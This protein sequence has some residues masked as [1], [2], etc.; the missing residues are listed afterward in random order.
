MKRFVMVLA[1]ALTAG[2]L[3]A[4]ADAD[5]KPV[6]RVKGHGTVV[7]AST[8]PD[9]AFGVIE[10]GY[11]YPRNGFRING[12]VYADGSASGAAFFDF[13]EEF[14]AEWGADYIELT[15]EIGSGTVSEDG[16]VVF[17]GLA[18]E[19][20]FL[21]GVVIFKEYTPFEIVVDAEGLFTLQW[22]ALPPFNLEITKGN[23]KVK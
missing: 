13:G 15:C 5:G 11:P 18:F 14:S 20:D 7:M 22:C 4:A 2:A 12:T 21:D 9:E 10:E 3:T 17:Q 16:A 19:Q 1:V 23:L 8:G 6:A